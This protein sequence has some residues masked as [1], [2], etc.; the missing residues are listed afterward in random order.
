MVDVLTWIALM[1]LIRNNN[2]F[3]STNKQQSYGVSRY[4]QCVPFKRKELFVLYF[5]NFMQMYIHVSM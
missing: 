4:L 2:Y 1:Y 3:V 5:F